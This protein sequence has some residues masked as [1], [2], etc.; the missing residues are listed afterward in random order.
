MS[1]YCR[2]THCRF[3]H[4]HV[5][6]AH[7]CGRCGNYGHGLVDCLSGRVDALWEVGQYDRM[8]VADWCTI[9]ECQ[10]K[11][12]HATS[13]HVCATCGTLGH[14]CLLLA[15]PVCRVV[16]TVQLE[17]FANSE[18]VA[19]CEKGPVVVLDKCK[20]A[21]ICKGCAIKIAATTL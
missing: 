14:Q 19:C 12:T 6:A 5:L 8:P 11:S 15:C 1:S 2:A 7:K 20:H 9:A 21:V 16:G 13:A 3:P 4:T 10:T 18:C 17:V